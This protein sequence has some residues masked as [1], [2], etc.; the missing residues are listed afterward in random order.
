MPQKGN[1]IRRGRKAEIRRRIELYDAFCSVP[2][3][4]C[5]PAIP[6]PELAGEE[7]SVWQRYLPVTTELGKVPFWFYHT[8][9]PFIEQ[10]EKA[11]KQH[12]FD[13]IEI[14]SRAGDP[15]AVGVM[16]GSMLFLFDEN[17][18]VGSAAHF[19]NGSAY[20]RPDQCKTVKRV[21]SIPLSRTTVVRLRPST[22]KSVYLFALQ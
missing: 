10:V 8:P 18:G 19:S 20:L 12:L 14:W 17:P 15:M 21:N 6:Y 9:Q 5:E 4:S 7:L 11:Q 3:S 22:P 1:R 2:A 13:R 16:G